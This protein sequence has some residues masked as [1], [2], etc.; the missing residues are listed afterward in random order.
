MGDARTVWREGLEAWAIPPEILQAAPV[1]PYGFPVEVFEHG[2]EEALRRPTPSH[3]IA[4]DALPQGGSVLDVGC[5]AGAGAL[6]LAGRARTLIG[7]DP[8]RAMLDAFARRAGELG[9]EHNE[10]E[11]SWPEAADA[12]E[13]ADVVLCFHVFWNVADLEPFARALDEHA[14]VRVVAELTAEHPLAWMNPLW[15]ELQGVE[16]PGGPTADDAV[17]VLEEIGLKPRV[18][19]WSGPLRLH[20]AEPERLVAFVRTRL[21]LPEDRDPEIQAALERHPIPGS[22]EIVTVWWD[23]SE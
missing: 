12:V 21:C 15:R 19:R 4:L 17:A 10:V 23:A 6:P 5:G 14:R 11:G 8:S 22:R 2:A 13:A 16:R 9:A 3:E 20:G 1:S 18:R 7:V